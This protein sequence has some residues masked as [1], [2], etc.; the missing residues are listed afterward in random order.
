M[1]ELSA[2]LE[3]LSADVP[4]PAE[5][6]RQPAELSQRTYKLL[7]LRDRAERRRP[8]LERV[9]AAAGDG[10]AEGAAARR[11]VEAL[12]ERWARVTGP[13]EDMHDAMKEVGTLEAST[14]GSPIQLP[15]RRLRKGTN[16]RYKNNC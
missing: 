1:A 9:A 15:C 2:F 5:P 7:Q 11:K 16:R 14:W 6:V 10:L 8:L 3:H 13:L 12:A 4:P